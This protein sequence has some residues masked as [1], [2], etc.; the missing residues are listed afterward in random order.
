MNESTVSAYIDIKGTFAR[1]DSGRSFSIN[2][3]WTWQKFGIFVSKVVPKIFCKKFG[4]AVA[5]MKSRLTNKTR[6]MYMGYQSI[7]RA[8]G[9]EK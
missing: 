3:K 5:S 8:F 4:V 7:K 9:L 2:Q 6:K 1:H